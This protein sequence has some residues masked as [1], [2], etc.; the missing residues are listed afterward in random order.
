[1]AEEN[2]IITASGKRRTQVADIDRSMYDFRYEDADAGR[3]LFTAR[4]LEAF[5]GKA[6]FDGDGKMSALDV[7]KYVSEQTLAASKTRF[8]ATQTP[9]ASA[10]DFADFAVAET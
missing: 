7:C 3:G 1:M 8:N 9:R 10:V 4:L 2:V 5:E 6:D